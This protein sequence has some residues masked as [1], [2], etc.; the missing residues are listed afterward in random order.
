[1]YDHEME[2]STEEAWT[3]IDLGTNARPLERVDYRRGGGR[4]GGSE[5]AA[6][7]PSSN[8]ESISIYSTNIV[9]IA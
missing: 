2:D 5:M 1:M 8:G 4:N 3:G 6:A 9:L 7:G